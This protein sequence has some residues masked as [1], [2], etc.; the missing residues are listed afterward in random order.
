[1]ARIGGTSV[2]IAVCGIAA[3]IGFLAWY[4]VRDRKLSEAPPRSASLPAP[5]VPTSLLAV[6][7]TLPYDRLAAAAE[8]AAP[9]SYSG[10]G[11]GPDVC[12]S[13]GPKG[14]G[15]DLSTKICAGTK[16]DFN[17]MRGPIALSA[18]PGNSIRVSIPLKV[19]G[20]GGFR[21]DGARLLSLDAKSFEASANAF[22]DITLALTRDWCPQVQVAANFSNL[23][24]RVE[25]VSR[26]WIG[27][28][29]LIGDSVR[30]QIHKMGEQLAGA[31]KC[32]EVRS[33]AQ[34]VWI[35]RSFP[36]SLPGDAQPLYVNLEPLSFGFSGI[37]TTTTAA[38]LLLTLSAHVSIT[39]A[40]IPM[41]STPLPPAQTIPLTSGALELAVPLR[42]SYES[43]EKH[44]MS[45][46]AGMPL[47]LQTPVGTASIRIDKITTYPSDGRIAIGAHVAIALPD[48]LFGTRGW[49]YLTARPVVSS[50]GTGV[51][52]EDLSYSRLLDNELGW[53]LTL[54]LDGEIRRRLSALGQ[55]EFGDTIATTEGILKSA[56]AN[57]AGEFSLD[58]GEPTLRLRRIIPG[59]DALF[60][61]GLLRSGA[62][63]VLAESR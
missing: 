15:I 6:R 57:R 5:D 25:I 23:D 30:Q 14:F 22:A 4:K 8:V 38:Y 2:L 42:V 58:I 27:V 55:V 51:R 10:S 56:L 7:I 49:V 31:V 45:A 9:Q 17:A 39:D 26:A 11:N 33:A 41:V 18:G 36:V 53:G 61:E 1:M 21:G 32:E 35:P 28:S 19:E 34:K 48:R 13:V 44:A 3:A 52:F 62:D 46:V 59:R 40:A 16:Y 47:S 37:K 29:D 60:V 43:I 54:L 20:H 12:A 50:D 24:A 63:A